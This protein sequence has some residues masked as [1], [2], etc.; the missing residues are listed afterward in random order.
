VVVIGMFTRSNFPSNSLQNFPVDLLQTQI[1]QSKHLSN[2]LPIFARSTNWV[3]RLFRLSNLCLKHVHR[4][5]LLRIW[6]FYWL[7]NACRPASSI[8]AACYYL[9]SSKQYYS[10]MLLLDVQHAVLQLHVIAWRPASSITATCK[11]RT[12]NLNEQFDHVNTI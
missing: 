9:T 2:Y 6:R 12:M 8:T 7:F 4:K 5:N 3:W 1:W 10:Y 11:F